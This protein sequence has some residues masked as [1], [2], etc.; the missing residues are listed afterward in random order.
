MTE[1]IDRS[2]APSALATEPLDAFT[3]IA[4]GAADT[5]GTKNG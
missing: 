2:A 4:E 5:I 1:I 3:N